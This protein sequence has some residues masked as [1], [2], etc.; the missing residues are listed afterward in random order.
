MFF[1]TFMT[2]SRPK[3][4]T[5]LTFQAR[6]PATRR[7]TCAAVVVATVLAPGIAGACAPSSTPVLRDHYIKRL[8]SE[9]VVLRQM[10]IVSVVMPGPVSE[11]RAE[12]SGS[13][14]SLKSV[15]NADVADAHRSR[16]TFITLYHTSGLPIAQVNELPMLHYWAVRPGAEKLTFVNNSQTPTLSHTLNFTVETRSFGSAEGSR[17]VRKAGLAQV[18]KP[19]Y[20][21]YT[22]ILEITLPSSAGAVWD[23]ASAAAANL[24]LK[25]KQKLP[26]NLMRL[27]FRPLASSSRSATL[28][29]VEGGNTYR[30]LVQHQPATAC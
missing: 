21:A 1:H 6:F 18:E 4:Q 23:T 5:L 24:E 13:G 8:S 2:P 27:V 3:P 22:E 10:D 28:S 16:K 25:E 30:F 7:V 15:S 20:L 11:W 12:M 9:T 26:D 19:V 14:G 17:T 29:L